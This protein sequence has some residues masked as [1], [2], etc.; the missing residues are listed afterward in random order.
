MIV[1]VSTLDVQV[2]KCYLFY[3]AGTIAQSYVYG[4][5]CNV[6][7]LLAKICEISKW[8]WIAEHC[9]SEITD[10]V[11]CNIQECITWAQQQYV[12]TYNESL[13]CDESINCNLTITESLLNA[14][15]NPI[16]IN[17]Q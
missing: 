8:L 15:T 9:P 14:C 4:I 5:S 3:A 2:L 11:Y 17:I 10:D 6:D 1:D 13:T 16:T 12:Y 7:E